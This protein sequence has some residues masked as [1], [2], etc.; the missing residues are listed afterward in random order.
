MLIRVPPRWHL[1]A[2]ACTPEGAALDR[3]RFLALAGFGALSAACG[4]TTPAGDPLALVDP[5]PTADRYPAPRSAAHAVDRPI[6]DERIAASYNNFYEFST[7][8]E[9]VWREVGAFRP[10]PWTLTVTGLVRKPLTLDLGE[11]VRRMPLE[12]RVYRFRCVEA[13]SMV[14]PWTGFP[15]ARLLAEA[16]PLP[17]ARFVRLI[18]ADRAAEMPG[19]KGQPW[20]PWPYFEALTL[21]EARHELTLLAT[22]IYGHALPRQHGAP[23]RL[24]APWKYG[25]KNIKSV[26]AIEL[27]AS[28]P[29]TFWNKLVPHEYDF[30]GNVLPQRPHPRWSQASERVIGSGERLPTLAYNGYA[31]EVAGLYGA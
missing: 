24:V 13:W 27:V 15:L 3:R 14:V 29:A 19:V 5:G 30:A 10:W 6:T 11:L 20:Y 23:V 31:A 21:A 22:G 26:V 28:Q 18:T 9:A 12:E 4:R 25:Y 7:D 16:D 17:E 2:S 1:P 8:K